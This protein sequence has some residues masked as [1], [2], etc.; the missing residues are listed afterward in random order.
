MDENQYVSDHTNAAKPAGMKGNS[1][2]CPPRP[3][4]PGHW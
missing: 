2:P 3:P 4:V 1:G